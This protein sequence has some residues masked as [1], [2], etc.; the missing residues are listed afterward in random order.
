MLALLLVCMTAQQPDFSMVAA[1]HKMDLPAQKIV[2]FKSDPIIKTVEVPVVKEVVKK[3]YVY[4]DK[5]GVEHEGQNKAALFNEVYLENQK[6]FRL[7]DS[8]GRTWE[9]QDRTVLEKFIADQNAQL[10]RP[11]FRTVPL[12]EPVWQPQAFY[13]PLTPMVNVR[14]GFSQA[15]CG[16][17]G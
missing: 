16:P 11:A 6:P 15:N 13:M 1:E 17:V 7:K 5:F 4:I 9:H 3:I 12:N 14:A 2:V 10:K 8:S